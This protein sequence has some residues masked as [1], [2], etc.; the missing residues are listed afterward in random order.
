MRHLACLGGRLRDPCD[1]IEHVASRRN[2]I[3]RRGLSH[4]GFI[5]HSFQRRPGRAC[6]VVR[7]AAGKTRG[8]Q[9]Q[10]HRRQQLWGGALDESAALERFEVLHVASAYE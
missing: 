3:R 1:L 6:E 4:K 7:H 2:L 10:G 8:R 5:H 9:A